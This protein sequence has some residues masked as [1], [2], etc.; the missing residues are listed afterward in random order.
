MIVNQIQAAILDHNLKQ[1]ILADHEAGLDDHAR[2]YFKKQATK[3]LR[4]T[5]MKT[6]KLANQIDGFQH[7]FNHYA[8]KWG[9]L[10]L[11][12]NIFLDIILVA[13]EFV[14]K[15]NQYFAMMELSNKQSIMRMINYD[16]NG[17]DISFTQCT[18]LLPKASEAI[19][20]AFIICKENSEVM[21]KEKT[22]SQMGNE[23][24]F[25]TELLLEC[26]MPQMSIKDSL[27]KLEMVIENTVAKEDELIEAKASASNYLT[28]CQQEA[29][30][31]TIED[32]CEAISSGDK[33]L[34]AKLL[35]EAKEMEIPKELSLPKK[36]ATIKKK[37]K[38]KTDLG[39]EIS[40]PIDTLMQRD[41]VKITTNENGSLSIELVDIGKII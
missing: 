36:G 33:E 23:H 17:K 2:A 8:Q 38:I 18:G 40:I 34:E 37:Q 19:E 30:I 11:D 26:S 35:D 27:H 16:A 7:Q 32:Y 21:V 5:N 10:Y 31:V 9:Q 4:S 41:C 13:V 15:D 3:L 22:I 25:I 39:F 6:A 28:K 12:N 29:Q 20:Q 14:D 1:M 24:N